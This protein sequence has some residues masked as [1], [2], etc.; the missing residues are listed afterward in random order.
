[1]DLVS[2]VSRPGQATVFERER[3][4]FRTVIEAGRA[5]WW[6]PPLLIVLGTLAALTEGLTIG[7]LIPLFSV[8]FDESSGSG[9][10]DAVVRWLGLNLT[11]TQLVGTLAGGI[12]TLAVLRAAVIWG[13][14][15]LSIWVSG[16]VIHRL[17]MALLAQL[18]EVGY[19]FLLS[20]DRG[21]I[22]DTLRAETWRVGAFLRGLAQALISACAVVVLALFLL[23]ISPTLTLWAAVA[24]TVITVIVRFMVGR[25]R[26]QGQEMMDLSAGLSRHTTELLGAMRTIRLFGQEQSECERFSRGSDELRRATQRLEATVAAIQPATELLYTP[27]FLGVLLAAWASGT[28][29]PTLIGFLVMLYRLQPHARR[30]DHLRVEVA[31]NRPAVQQIADLLETTDKP[32][33]SSG[34]RPFE[35]LREGIEFESAGFTYGNDSEDRPAVSSLSFRIERRQLTAIV[36]ESGAGKSTAVNLLF[37]LYDPT[38]GRILV[39]G[40]P[41]DELRLRDWRRRLAFSG[42]DTELVGETIHDA[43][44]FAL[45]DA[46]RA[47]VEQAAEMANAAEFIL[48]LPQG[49]DTPIGHE[50]VRLSAGQRQRLGLARA[51]LCDPEILVLDEATNALDPLSERLIQDAL[52]TIRGKLTIV[53]I[54]HRLTS[55]RGA[56]KV[57]VLEDGQVAEEGAPGDLLDRPDGAFSKLWRAH[58]S[59]AGQVRA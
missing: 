5:Y 15:A 42:Q 46:D 57:I 44:A 29:F 52:E 34:H 8:I 26:R 20:S 45:P 23:A 39:D 40:T 18:F 48:K 36:G 2:E 55:I 19:V 11:D 10:I 51:L 30:L 22:Y 7:L 37:R 59:A 56:D 14:E 16:Q 33:L 1:M 32:Y 17:R 21:R 50:G 58:E 41:L 3:R 12:L 49:Y 27:L 47:S 43:I 53:M 38:S 54:A 35:R 31:G 24:A 4:L 25:A 28:G 6:T 13:Y 9:T